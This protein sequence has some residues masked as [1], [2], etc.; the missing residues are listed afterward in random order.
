MMTI[1]QTLSEPLEVHLKL[2][3][4]ARRNRVLELLEQVGLSRRTPTVTR[5]RLSGGQRQRIAI[6]GCS[7]RTRC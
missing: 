7:R 6:A 4:A 3:R 1:E 5:T 2:D